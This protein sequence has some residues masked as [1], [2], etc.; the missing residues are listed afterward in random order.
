MTEAHVIALANL[1]AGVGKTSLTLALGTTLAE[2]GHRV[3]LI[4]LDPQSSLT[5]ACGVEDA[6]DANLSQVIGTTIPG[7][8][9]IWDVLKEIVPG[10]Y[11]FLAPSDIALAHSEYG[12]NARMG[13]E[14]V[15]HQ[16]LNDVRPNFD[17]VL[18]D[19]PSSLGLLTLNG[20][21]SSNTIL[22]PTQPH[23]SHMR[24][25]WLFLGTME[26]IKRE[27]NSNLSLLGILLTYYNPSLPHHQTVLSTMRAGGLPILPV[28]LEPAE[29]EDSELPTMGTTTY[30]PGS[31]RALEQLAMLVEESRQSGGGTGPLRTVRL[32]RAQQSSS[33]SSRS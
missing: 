15:L 16:A 8:V 30:V 22:V 14:F 13:R 27:L 18:I 5:V 32:R 26:R 25:L 10:N 33:L 23:L 6:A 19:C 2:R 9:P 28:A 12:L 29:G 3:L 11:I 1:R 4:D 20:L 31:Y 24:G 17:Y 21:A 7:R